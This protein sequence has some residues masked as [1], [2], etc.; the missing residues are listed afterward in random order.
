MIKEIS[1]N[2]LLLIKSFEGFRSR[3]YYDSVGVLTIGYGSTNAMKSII[4]REIIKNSSCT[5]LEASLWLKKAIDNKYGKIVQKYDDKYHWNQNEYDALCSFAY[6][7][8]SIDQLTDNGKRDRKTIA[9]K[10]LQYN[11]AGGKVLSGLVTRRRK[12]RALFITPVAT[13]ETKLKNNY[14]PKCDTK[15]ESI[16]KGL[17][18]VGE[19]DTSLNHRKKIALGNGFSSYSGTAKQNIEL[20][21]KLK[22]GK[23]LKVD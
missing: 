9:D 22:A 23:L 2:G 6:N 18:A 20:L 13:V 16:I 4:G 8:G 11:K 7:I 5:E 19:K 10:M 21:A 14:Y 17:S 15:E 12:E 1:N 3:A